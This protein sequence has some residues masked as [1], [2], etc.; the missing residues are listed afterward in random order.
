[1]D[2]E[3]HHVTPALHGVK[4]RALLAYL[5]INRGR[6]FSREEMIQAIWAEDRTSDPGQSLRKL[7][8]SLRAAL[9][10]DVL[11]GRHTIELRLPS[12]TWIDLE[13]AQRAIQVADAAL[14]TG[15]WRDAWT[16]AH[17]TLNIA[18]R[19]FLAGFDAPW[20]DEVRRDLNELELRALEVITRAGIG[21]GGS[22]LAGGER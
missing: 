11:A 10:V 16:Q 7:L 5:V 12:D 17:I 15:G 9:G 4:G 21:L 8:S 22:E 19:P 2:Y 13:A 1:M 6:G 3:G 18:G 20:V 14:A